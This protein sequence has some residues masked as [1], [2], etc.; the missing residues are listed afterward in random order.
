MAYPW[1]VPLRNT[2]STSMAR[3]PGGI[4]SLGIGYLY[5]GGGGMSIQRP[6]YDLRAVSQTAAAGGRSR[7][8]D[9]VCRRLL[10]RPSVLDWGLW[11]DAQ[12]AGGVEGEVGVAEEL[13]G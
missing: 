11:F 7:R 2:R 1:R 5:I 13:A 4:G 10:E 6:L 3:V 8:F 12:F 9:A